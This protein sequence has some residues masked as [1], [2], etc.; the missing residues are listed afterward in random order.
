VVA[1]LCLAPVALAQDPNS[2]TD[3]EKQ[4]GWTLLFDGKTAD[5][6]RGYKQ[7]GFPAKGWTTDG[8]LRCSKGG[9]GGDLVTETDYTSFELVFE[10]LV[11]PGANS[12][13]LY[14]VSEEG[15]Y[16]WRTGPEYQILDDAAHGD[17]K[18]EK[19][20]AA[21]LYAV[22]APAGKK[23]HKPGEW[24]Q[25]RIVV[26]GQR[27]EHWLNG[28]KVCA[29][30]IGSD[31][32]KNAVAASKWKSVPTFAASAKGRIALQDHGDEVAFRGLKLRPLGAVSTTEAAAAPA[33]GPLFNGKD[34][35][36]WTVFVEPGK[37]A[38]GLWQVKDGVLVTRGQPMGYLR[39]TKDF[40]N[41]VLE[42]D[43]RWPE[44]GG[45]NSGV[46]FRMQDPDKVWPKSIEAQLQ[47]GN[48]G[49]FWNI[50]GFLMKPA[51]ERTT[52][53]NTKKLENAEKPKGEWN[54]YKITADGG[55]VKL[56][57]NGKLVNEASDCAALP[58]KICLQSEGAEI[59]FKDIRI[60]ELAGK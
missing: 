33:G 39:T 20:S 1:L 24:N 46:L 55:S 23:V 51:A 34:L 29:I 13:V 30:T 19:T 58:G 42:L 5:G 4:A 2:L 48:A 25:G 11:T 32:W 7:K 9:G 35:T 50:G 37:S 52:G 12:G 49:D 38:E 54:H 41:F 6:W 3:A 44:R 45:G 26:D 57:I 8:A 14:R 10:W 16:S 60:Q 47:H 59:H 17:G 18:N 43:W 36:G 56:E 27:I 31:E 15:D 40:T 22:C 28:M 21:S 53:R